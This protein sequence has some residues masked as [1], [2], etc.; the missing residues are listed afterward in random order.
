MIKSN[1]KFHSERGHLVQ[2]AILV[3]LIAGTV[4][5]ALV[6]NHGFANRPFDNVAVELGGGSQGTG[7]TIEMPDG[8]QG[9]RF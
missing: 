3:A 7:V 1:R 4:L 5:F 9:T 8:P 2:E 6:G